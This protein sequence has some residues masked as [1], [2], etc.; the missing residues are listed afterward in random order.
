MQVPFVRVEDARGP[1][2]FQLIWRAMIAQPGMRD[3]ALDGWARILFFGV[4]Y[5]AL[6]ALA[7]VI[8]IGLVV[9]GVHVL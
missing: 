3:T 1:H 4:L 2:F 8:A 6:V 5:I 7:A 9:L